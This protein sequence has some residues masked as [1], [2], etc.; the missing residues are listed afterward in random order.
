[1][2]VGTSRP[3]CEILNL[4]EKHSPLFDAG[5]Q[6]QRFVVSESVTSHIPTYIAL[7]DSNV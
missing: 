5:D 3:A 7:R 2:L 4:V 6:F 1:M